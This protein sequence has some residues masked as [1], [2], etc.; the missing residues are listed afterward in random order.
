M[1]GQEW[2]KSK[3]Y[4][5]Q[6]M[7]LKFVL[8]W[9]RTLEGEVPFLLD[10]PLSC[11]EKIR[12]CHAVACCWCRDSQTSGWCWQIPGSGKKVASLFERHDTPEGHLLFQSFWHQLSSRSAAVQILGLGDTSTSRHSSYPANTVGLI[13]F[14]SPR[15]YVLGTV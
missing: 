6:G 14:L 3:E 1:E 12:L 9:V 11:A 10:L 13:P 5:S 15:S 7:A 8:I 2:E 4:Y